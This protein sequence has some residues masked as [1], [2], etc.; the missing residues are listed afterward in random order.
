MHNYNLK[1]KTRDN[2]SLPNETKSPVPK[3]PTEMKS[4]KHKFPE[5][6]KKPKKKLKRTKDPNQP[7][8]PPT[9]FFVFMEEFR[10][11][12]TDANPNYKGIAM[13]AK[14]GGKR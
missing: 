8:K 11:I 10:K 2:L 9:T 3:K 12:Y 1:S 7:K 6:Q 4:S 13:V 14:E 5:V